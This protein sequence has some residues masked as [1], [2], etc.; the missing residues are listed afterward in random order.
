MTAAKSGACN[1]MFYGL[2]A[3]QLRSGFGGQCLSRM[4]TSPV[5]GFGTSGRDHLKKTF[6]SSEHDRA[7]CR[8]AG[9][10]NSQGAIY[11]TTT[12]FG[13]QQTST[14]TSSPTFRFGTS[15]RADITSK[16]KAPGAGEYRSMSSVGKQVDSTKQTAGKASFGS[17]SRDDLG[18]VF[19]STDH[20]KINYG[21]ESPGPSRYQSQGAV[22]KQNLSEKTTFPSWR[23]GTEKRFNYDFIQRAVGIPG[24]GQY[25]N[26]I[27]CGRQVLSKKSTLP[28]IGFGSSSRD[29]CKK[30]FI[31]PEHEKSNFGVFSPGP[32]TGLQKSAVGKQPLAVNRSSST[33]SFGTQKRLKE[34]L[35]PVP[36]PGTYA[37]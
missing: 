15:Q 12:G 31:S 2:G 35:N 1:D 23:L 20:E 22:G 4:R 16:S 5:Y 29:S 36:G 33:W 32:C 21:V 37:A 10:N 7:Q 26:T 3:G 19:I 17:S 6:I 8:S 30:L 14:N 13:F 24:A 28:S 18:K 25:S 27:A 34:H 9:G 11:R